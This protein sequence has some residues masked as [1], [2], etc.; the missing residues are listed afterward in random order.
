[1]KFDYTKY[2]IWLNKKWTIYFAAWFF[3]IYTDA[4]D[5]RKNIW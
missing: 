3:D 2:K 4:Y 5:A 1:M